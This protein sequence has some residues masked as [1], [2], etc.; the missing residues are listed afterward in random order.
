MSLTIENQTINRRLGV[1]RDYIAQHYQAVEGDFKLGN[2][3]YLINEPCGSIQ[4]TTKYIVIIHGNDLGINQTKLK[5]Q[6]IN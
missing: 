4:E 5:V 2:V 1:V 3:L 6:A